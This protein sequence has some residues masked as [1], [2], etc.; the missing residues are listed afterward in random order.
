MHF[1]LPRELSPDLSTRD[2]VYLFGNFASYKNGPH[3]GPEGVQSPA[4]V[5]SSCVNSSSVCEHLTWEPRSTLPLLCAQER[6]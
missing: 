6:S 2:A 1:P 3:E 4:F 5:Y